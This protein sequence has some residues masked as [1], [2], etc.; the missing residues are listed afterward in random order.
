MLRF[1]RFRWAACQLDILKECL[2]EEAVE[3]TLASLP[4]TLEGTYARILTCIKEAY[5]E[6]AIRILQFLTFSE[7]PLTIHEAVDVLAI[8]LSK[9]PQF[10]PKRRLQIPQEIM[11]I[12]P[13]LISLVIRQV[14]SDKEV[15]Q[16]QLAHSSVK[17]YLT[18]ERLEATIK[19]SFTQTS[20]T[21][22]ITRVCLAYMSH[23]D[24]QRSIQE[25]RAEFPLM[26]YSER[27]WMDHALSAET[28]KDVQESIL[29]FFLQQTQAYAAWGM[30]FEADESR[31]E[32]Q[33]NIGTPL[34]YASLA[35][36]QHTTQRLLE[37]KA[38]VNAR[39][40]YYG[41]ALQA[42]SRRGHT[43][44]VQLLLDKGAYIN[45]EGGDC[46]TA[47]RAASEYGH[48]E[49]VQRLLDH[50]AYSI[51][52][53]IY[54]TEQR[55]NY[56]CWEAAGPLVKLFQKELLEGT[57]ECL[58][59]LQN[60]FPHSVFYQLYMFGKTP[61]TATPWITITSRSKA[62]R[63]LYRKALQRSSIMRSD[64]F[65]GIG[66][67]DAPLPLEFENLQFI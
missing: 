41:N 49:V 23:L 53:R 32:P 48:K 18:S 38:D 56:T 44:I 13:S 39:G 29:N 2:H 35:G 50:G 46:G 61:K 20:A 33:Q 66:V 51:G 6:D 60:P 47:I 64:K 26:Q 21:G 27:Y 24:E 7:R 22:C 45:A 42:A 15:M 58:N 55:R 34:Y 16:L 19:K 37:N 3:E 43:E 65:R 5:R 8:D 9:D 1:D 36:L 63:K 67:A 54:F 52:R 25:T 59:Q 11:K 10:N 31:T 4:K 28:E 62:T 40:G 57:D 30:H 17:E 12:C 14:G